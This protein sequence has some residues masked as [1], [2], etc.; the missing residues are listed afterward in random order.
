MIP[1]G[2]EDEQEGEDAPRF[3]GFASGNAKF[4]ERR[5]AEFNGDRQQPWHTFLS[6][7]IHNQM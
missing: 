3:D 6:E 7:G 1:V 5:Q 4:L 2:V